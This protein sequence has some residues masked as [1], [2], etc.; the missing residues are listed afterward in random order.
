VLKNGGYVYAETPFLFPVH[1]GPYDFTRFTAGGHRRLFRNFIA[2]EN[3]MAS[4]PA[5]ALTL[6][7]RSFFL[8]LSTARGM[9]IFARLVLPFFIFWLKYFDRWLMKKPHAA[10]YAAA[11]YF[12]GR[13]NAFPISD[14]DVIATHWSRRP[15]SGR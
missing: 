9:R 4:G 8:S 7:I 10:D 13:K 6:S 12:I 15:G 14:R 2:I 3:E 11:F 5:T 1:M